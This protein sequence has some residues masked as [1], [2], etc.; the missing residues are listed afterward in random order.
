MPIRIR[1]RGPNADRELAALYAW[2]GDEA[3]IREHAV[4]SMVAAEPG[5]SDMGAAFNAIQLM[6][7]DGFQAASLALAYVSW[8]A[9][10]TGRPDVVIE[11]DGGQEVA[12]DGDDLAVAK[13][14]ADIMP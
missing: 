9:T 8:R 11:A 13:T 14:I 12:L 3:S 2:L 4:L 1:M 10:R 6:L 7:D 5:P